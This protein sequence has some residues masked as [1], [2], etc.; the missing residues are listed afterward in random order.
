MS[1]QKRCSHWITSGWPYGQN[2]GVASSHLSYAEAKA[3]LPGFPKAPSQLQRWWWSWD[4]FRP[5]TGCTKQ[6]E[7]VS[8]TTQLQESLLSRRLLQEHKRASKDT[9]TA[10]LLW[11]SKGKS[12][13]G[14]DLQH[15]CMTASARREQ[16][17]PA[18]W[19]LLWTER[20]RDWAGSN[21]INSGDR[22]CIAYPP[23]HNI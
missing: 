10:E 4:Q 3:A 15:I 12:R 16:P 21:E 5:Y 19:Q 1:L 9:G 11:D 14:G 2:S 22:W 13:R 23:T 7:K 17:Q 6:G 18:T 20:W 8:Q